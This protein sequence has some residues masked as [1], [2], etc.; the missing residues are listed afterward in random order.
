MYG[1]TDAP[2]LF[3]L[4]LIQFLLDNT[5]AWQ[6]VY[7]DNHFPFWLDETRTY[8][9]LTAI[10]HVDDLL[11][12]GAAEIIYWLQ[13]MLEGRFGPLKRQTLPCT[14]AGLE[15]GWV[16]PECLLQHQFSFVSKLKQIE[17]SKVRKSERAA[18]CYKSPYSSDSPKMNLIV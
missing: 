6:S 18:L 1:F 7:D 8:L 16:N 2:L 4:A 10:V 9:I 15:Y 5:G 17:I 11:L 12:A 14:H 3:R 13:R